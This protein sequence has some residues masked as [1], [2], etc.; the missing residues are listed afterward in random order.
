[1]GKIVKSSFVSLDGVV[2]DPAGNEGFGA[3][4][5][6]ARSRTAKTSASWRSTKRW[7]PR[8]C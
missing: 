1:M 8:R 4:A 6:S 2:Q 3:G 7:P 5:G